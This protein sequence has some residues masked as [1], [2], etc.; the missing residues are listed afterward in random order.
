MGAEMG[1]L[2]SLLWT[3]WGLALFVALVMAA[4]R[5]RWW[6]A[7]ALASAFGAALVLAVQTDVIGDPW[8]GYCLWAL[9]GLALAWVPLTG[10]GD[11][12]AGGHRARAPEGERPRARSRVLP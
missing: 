11:R 8:M 9:A 12:P 10:D 6:G 3:A 2:G 7:V 4:R 1:I 5:T